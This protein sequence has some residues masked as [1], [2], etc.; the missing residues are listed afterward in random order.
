MDDNNHHKIALPAAPL[1][2]SAD[3]YHESITTQQVDLEPLGNIGENANTN[4]GAPEQVLHFDASRSVE[5]SA[6]MEVTTQVLDTL[7]S[8][9]WSMMVD[10]PP[11]SVAQGEQADEIL[12]QPGSPDKTATKRILPDWMTTAPVVVTKRSLYLNTQTRHRKKQDLVE[13]EENEASA[14][15]KYIYR[16][17]LNPSEMSL[18]RV[19]CFDVESTGF[20]S[21]DGIIEIGAVE[22]ILGQRTGALFQSYIKPSVP[23]NSHAAEVHGITNMMLAS[24]PPAHVVIPSFLSWVGSSPLVAHNARFDMRM[25]VACH[26]FYHLLHFFCS[27]SSLKQP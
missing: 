7:D 21:T 23:I 17:I 2:D 9:D 27:S 16:D 1:D 12:S 5:H 22:Y 6:D 14:D 24:A 15:S 3:S 20:A 10:N 13:A 18:D 8:L 11:P 19:I 25:Y 4:P 26:V